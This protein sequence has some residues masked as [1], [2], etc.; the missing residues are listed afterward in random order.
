MPPFMDFHPD[1]KLAAEAL[2]QIAGTRHMRA[3]QFGGAARLP[4]NRPG[5][6]DENQGVHSEGPPVRTQLRPPGSQ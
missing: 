6:G 4:E 5:D 3:D 2:A 1:Q